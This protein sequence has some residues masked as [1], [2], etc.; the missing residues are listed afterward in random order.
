[1][2]TAEEPQPKEEKD[3]A[4][5]ETNNDEEDEPIAVRI[6]TKLS[7]FFSANTGLVTGKVSLK[8]RVLLLS[9]PQTVVVIIC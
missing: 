7:L 1:M 4:T 8:L 6:I 3:K 5:E 2:E 9:A